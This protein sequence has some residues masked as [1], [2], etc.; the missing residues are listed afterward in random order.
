MKTISCPRALILKI[1][2]ATNQHEG[3]SRHRCDL[4]NCLA[5]LFREFHVSL[6]LTS[7]TLPKSGTPGGP[8]MGVGMTLVNEDITIIQNKGSRTCQYAHGAG[9]RGLLSKASL[10]VRQIQSSGARAGLHRSPEVR[11]EL[12]RS[13]RLRCNSADWRAPIAPDVVTHQTIWSLSAAM[14]GPL[15]QPRRATGCSATTEGNGVHHNCQPGSLCRFFC[16]C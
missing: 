4:P 9:G 11:D 3:A 2:P 7:K 1:E 12:K 6:G 8:G 13:T 15:E 10:A 14:M 16:L 5:S